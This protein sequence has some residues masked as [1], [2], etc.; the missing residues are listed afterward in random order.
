MGNFSTRQD[1][2]LN[3]FSN[4]RIQEITKTLSFRAI[5]VPGQENF[6]F[7]HDGTNPFATLV[8][9][10]DEGQE[11]IILGIFLLFVNNETRHDVMFNVN[12]LFVGKKTNQD[13]PHVD[14]SGNLKIFCPA[15]YNNT[16]NGN[17]RILYKPRLKDDVLRTYAGLERAIVECLPTQTIFEIT[18]PI[19]HFIVHNEHLLEPVKY[20]KN[21]N[22]Q[23]ITAD[24]E[25]LQRVIKFFSNTIFDDMHP[26]RFE[27]T[28]ISGKVSRELM[29]DVQN[30][31]NVV[32]LPN[33]TAIIQINYLLISPGEQQ[34][35]HLE[36]K[37]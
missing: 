5:V 6:V 29:D 27:G 19:A 1:V 17:D 34:M 20:V 32:N 14:D 31:K 16:V 11:A 21:E 24:P 30:K 35:K 22:T 8:S 13:V 25:F 18:H 4:P 12:E 28:T 10:N 33:I 23:T 36:M 7:S 26:T 37:V 9:Q 2:Y 3:Q 15:R